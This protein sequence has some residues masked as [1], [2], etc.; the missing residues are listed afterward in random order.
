MHTEIVGVKK[1]LLISMT[2]SAGR[3]RHT[4]R[5]RPAGKALAHP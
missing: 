3:L 2:D 5:A 4:F 1:A